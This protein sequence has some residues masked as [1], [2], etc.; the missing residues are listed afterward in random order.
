MVCR[1]GQEG[2]RVS[3]CGH[4]A[5]KEK[6]VNFSRFYACVF[7]GRPLTRKGEKVQCDT[8]SAY[9]ITFSHLFRCE[10]IVVTSQFNTVKN[11]ND[12]LEPTLKLILVQIVEVF[13]FYRWFC[14]GRHVI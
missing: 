5:D 13:I 4:F 9:A 3:Q 2:R 7:Y 14:V 8:C 11:S 6:G 1:H 12:S 10:A